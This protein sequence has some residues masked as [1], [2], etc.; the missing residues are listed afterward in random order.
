MVGEEA[1][2][3]VPLTETLAR[4]KLRVSKCRLTSGMCLPQ[5]LTFS[6]VVQICVYCYGHACCC[7]LRRV[8]LPKNSGRNCSFFQNSVFPLSLVSSL[9]HFLVHFMT[10]WPEK[11]SQLERFRSIS[12]T[13]PWLRIQSWYQETIKGEKTWSLKR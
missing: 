5:K 4:E 1:A 13:P 10:S 9:A 8:A 11:T 6:G 12:G 7:F 3:P 2:D